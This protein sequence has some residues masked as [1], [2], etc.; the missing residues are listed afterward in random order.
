MRQ[1]R[2]FTSS[3]LLVA[4]IS[5]SAATA[6][7]TQDA[8]N[9]SAIGKQ[10]TGFSLQDFRG[11][12]HAL[13]DFD[14]SKVIVVAFLGTECPLV[15]LYA[16]KL[17]EMSSKYADDGVAFLGINS[18]RQDSITEIA[19]QARVQKIEFPLL[20]DSRNE[21]ADLFGAERTPEVFVLD[22]D[23]KVRYHGRID[24]Q[25]HYE[26]QRADVK[27][28]YLIDAIDALLAGK[29][30]EVKET[31]VVGCHIGRIL[32]ADENSKVTYSNQIS[33]ILQNNCVQCHRAGEIAPFALTDYDEVVGWAEMIE[34]V[35][36][37]QRMPPWHADPAHGEFKN[38]ARLSNE[39]KELIYAWV[40]AGAPEGDPKDL[41]EPR[42]FVEGWRIGEPD[43]VIEM[44]SKPFQVP[45]RGEVKYQYF[46][47]DPQWKEDKY[48]VAAE[49]RAGNRAVVHHIIVGHTGKIEAR[50]RSHGLK[51]DWITAMA[52]GSLPLILEDGMAKFVPAGSKLVF[53][54]HYTPNGT[55]TEDLSYVGFKFG[56]AK[57]V[58]HIVGTNKAANSRFVIP[59][60]AANHRVE[61][62]YRF[63]KDTLM[64]AMFPHMHLRGKS[65]R[66]TAIYP[67]GKEEILLN[68]PN[69]DFNWQ[70]GYA[71][72]EPKLMPAGTRLHCVAHF[73][74]SE[75]NL[76][77]P[78]PTQAVRWGDQT[79]EEMMI[80]YFDMCFVED[81]QEPTLGPRTE[82]FVSAAKD[83]NTKINDELRTLAGE[84]LASDEQLMAF[85][86][87]LRE[88]VPQ[89]DRVCITSAHDEELT[90]EMV[91]QE[92]VLRKVVG[93][94]KL[95]VDADGMV[96][97]EYAQQEA[98][99][100]NA[101]ISRL[102]SGDM[103]FM[104]RRFASGM[105][106]PARYQDKAATINFWSSEP[107]AFPPEAVALLERI[108]AA[109]QP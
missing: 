7:E 30:V 99:K 11:K 105:H 31:E 71:F 42:K 108:A 62:D 66:Y 23:R 64:L 61:A 27:R 97:A 33:R 79:W 19:H 102:P 65:F 107:G 76:A 93:G 40:K 6:E 98:T 106:V 75:D 96:L 78:D 17:G 73:D 49:A 50:S 21:V 82:K 94:A 34:E 45:A 25:Y 22:A 59:S 20:K 12:Q 46:V 92:G 47:V 77:N 58:E 38:D 32:Q 28:N 14:D 74:N 51:S 57:D 81:L 68:V 109:M 3:L 5:Y 53:Q 95:V 29:D 41:P 4:F 39:E 80:G 52:P 43:E 100:V 89:L 35:V 13:H 101:D 54:M 67:D 87:K 86:V 104:A 1:I 70:N 83:D 56:D 48:I 60:H 69:Y 85:A 90:V 8:K 36:Q 16:G 103:R 44:R 2:L 55:A 18:N 15:Q 37:E 10:I 63:S 88:L 24:D 26:I 72:T 9:A 91:A 84:A